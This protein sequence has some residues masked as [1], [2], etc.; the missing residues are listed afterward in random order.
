MSN[1]YHPALEEYPQNERISF[2]SKPLGNGFGDVWGILLGYA[3]KVWDIGF[4]LKLAISKRCLESSL[5]HTPWPCLR[6]HQAASR[7]RNCYLILSTHQ[8]SCFRNQSNKLQ[9]IFQSSF[10]TEIHSSRD[11]DLIC[12]NKNNQKKHT[13]TWDDPLP[14]NG[15]SRFDADISLAA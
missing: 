9:N 3:A 11:E 12:W 6:G 13:V 2:L 4:C 8:T 10:E 15:K 14:N 7:V 1:N 5:G